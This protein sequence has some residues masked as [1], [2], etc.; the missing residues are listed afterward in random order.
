[1][2]RF[3]DNI[4]ATHMPKA[5][6]DMSF[7]KLTAAAQKSLPAAQRQWLGPVLEQ[8]QSFVHIAAD[9]GEQLDTIVAESISSAFERHTD[10]EQNYPG[11]RRK[12]AEDFEKTMV[13]SKGFTS[14]L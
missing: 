6:L 1:M 2:T 3:I 14:I 4:V 11:A 7:S 10:K 8:C 5:M 13:I 9:L 12:A